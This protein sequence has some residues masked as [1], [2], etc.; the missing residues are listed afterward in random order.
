MNYSD[1][2]NVLETLV[3][4]WVWI[5]N[6][7]FNKV[8]LTSTIEYNV[9]FTALCNNDSLCHLDRDLHALYQELSSIFSEDSNQQSSREL[10]MKVS[11]CI[12]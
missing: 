5:I 2:Q 8:E 4:I 10:L 12:R 11:T 9:Q 6:R 3:W 1:L 7:K